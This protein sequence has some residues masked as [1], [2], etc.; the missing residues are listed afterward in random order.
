MF[1]LDAFQIWT[2]EKWLEITSYVGNG[3]CLTKSFSG[4]VLFYQTSVKKAGWLEF[5][6]DIKSDRRNLS[7]K[8]AMHVPN[9]SQQLLNITKQLKMMEFHHNMMEFCHKAVPKK[10]RLF[11]VNRNP[12]I[13]KGVRK[14]E[15]MVETSLLQ[16]GESHFFRRTTFRNNLPKQKSPPLLKKNPPLKSL[17]I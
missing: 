12:A 1:Q 11:I 7:R 6:E 13:T 3:C 17:E 14:N 5:Q 9:L 15:K 4:T 2:N 16:V 10:K 8:F